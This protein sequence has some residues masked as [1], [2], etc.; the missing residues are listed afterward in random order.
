MERLKRIPSTWPK[1]RVER[2]CQPMLHTT[3][4]GRSAWT[5]PTKDSR[6]SLS[7]T[8]K[9]VSGCTISVALGACSETRYS[10]DPDFDSTGSVWMT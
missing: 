10:Q 6:L 4:V 2:E 9:F 3:T 1:I 7:D 5:T 8:K